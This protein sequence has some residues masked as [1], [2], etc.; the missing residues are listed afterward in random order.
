MYMSYESRITYSSR[1]RILSSRTL[2]DARVSTAIS[3][4]PLGPA[5]PGTEYSGRPSGRTRCSR[6]TRFPVKYK[7]ARGP[8]AR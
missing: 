3:A 5:I 8:R 2:L 7:L 4:L 6:P 1:V